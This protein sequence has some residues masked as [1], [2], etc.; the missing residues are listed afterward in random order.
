LIDY[1]TGKGVLKTVDGTKDMNDV[2]ADIV[3]ILG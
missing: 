2:F 1:Y 3:G